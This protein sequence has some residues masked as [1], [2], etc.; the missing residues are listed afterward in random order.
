[1]NNRVSHEEDLEE[2]VYPSVTMQIGELLILRKTAP[3]VVS[4]NLAIFFFFVGLC[5]FL[6]KDF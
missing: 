4:P 5:F 1:M 2:D 3:T 6:R